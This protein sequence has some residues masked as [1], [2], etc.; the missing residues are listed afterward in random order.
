MLPLTSHEPRP[1]SRPPSIAGSNGG[2][3]MPSVG[4]VS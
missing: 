2:I 4:T 3:V 1:Y